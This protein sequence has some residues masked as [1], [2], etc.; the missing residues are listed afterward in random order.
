MFI[1]TKAARTSS[2]LM[3]RPDDDHSPEGRNFIKRRRIVKRINLDLDW[4]F[5]AGRLH[6]ERVNLPHDHSVKMPRKPDSLMAERGGYFQGGECEYRKKLP[7]GLAGRVVLEVEGAYMNAEVFVNGN[8]VAFHPY[9]YTSFLVEL[10]PWLKPGG[11]NELAIR[12]SNNAQPNSRWYSGT[13]LYRHV[14]LQV[15]DGPHVAPWGVFVT[16]PVVGTDRAVIHVE[17]EI[18]GEGLLR[19][20]LLD[21]HGVVI[22]LHESPAVSGVNVR[23]V[24]IADVRLWEPEDPYL[25]TLRSELVAGGL[26]ADAVETAVGIRSIALDR[27]RGLLLN[28][29]P[30]KLKGGCVHHDCGMLGAAAW[31]AAEERKVLAHKNAGFN[32]IRCAHNPPSPAFLDACDRHGMIVMDEAFDCWRMG[33]TPYDYHLYFEDWWRR[34]IESMVRR[35]R[36]HPAIFFWS[37]GNEVPERF[38]MSGGNEL[39]A[40]LAAAVRALDSSRFV[41]NALTFAYEMEIEDFA[42]DSMAFSAPLDVVGYNYMW[43]RYGEDLAAFPERFILGTESYPSAAFDNWKMA[44]DHP[45]VLGDCVW[46]SMDNIGEAGLGRSILPGESSL[47]AGAKYPWLLSNCGDLDMLGLPRPQSLYRQIVWGHRSKPW[48]AVHRPNGKG[49]KTEGTPWGWPD[50]HHSWSWPEAAGM[51]VFIDVYSAADEVELLVNGIS[52]GRKP[53]GHANRHVASFETSYEAGCIRAIAYVGGT[54]TGEDAV[55]TC[56]LPYA[57]RLESDRSEIPAA[58]GGLAYVTA[59][60]VDERGN[61]VPWARNELHF[62]VSG[63]G[64]LLASGTGNPMAE[65]AFA[66]NR[67]RAFNGIAMAAVRSTGKSGQA[68]VTV[69]AEGLVTQQLAIAAG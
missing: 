9:G 34:D 7:A 38:G 20:T 32:M 52:L 28:D 19:H 27:D 12:I 64:A 46:T 62:T 29:K 33:K 55:S 66:G 13:G 8:R 60:V 35:D 36:N 49:L 17:T 47:Y 30:L 26:A 54:V 51:R 21:A 41:T 3:S 58:W 68:L 69:S 44:L 53:A 42:K 11:D 56:G 45:R 6:H 39:S 63:A 15:A 22:A 37:T 5:S 1:V 57:I 10:T 16:T 2:L 31:D 67:Q 61:P 50:V 18:V 43:E 24:S 14:W 59:T 25:Y 48:I 65:D 40:Q 23:D 4:Q